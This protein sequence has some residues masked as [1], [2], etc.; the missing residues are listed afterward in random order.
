VLYNLL[1]DNSGANAEMNVE[2]AENARR[3][4]RGVTVAMSD[5]ENQIKG[6]AE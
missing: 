4:F 3:L 6:V 1:K 5:L 2:T